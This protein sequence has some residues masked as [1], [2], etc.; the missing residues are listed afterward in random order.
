[1]KTAKRV[2]AVFIALVMAFGVFSVAVTAADLKVGDASLGTT[3][4]GLKFY[5]YVDGVPSTTPLEDGATL[6]QGDIVDVAVL[7]STDFYTH[8]VSVQVVFDKRV[9][10][11]YDGGAA[12]TAKNTKIWDSYVQKANPDN[13]KTNQDIDGVY[14]NFYDTLSSNDSAAYTGSSNNNTAGM[15]PAVWKN[16]SS[17]KADYANMTNV[18]LAFQSAAETANSGNKL[19]NVP[20]DEYARFPIIVVADEVPDGANATISVPLDCCKTASSQSTS[21]VYAKKTANNDGNSASQQNTQDWGSCKDVTNAIATFNIGASAP[22]EPTVTFKN[23]D[24]TDLAFENVTTAGG[25]TVAVSSLKAGDVIVL[26][27]PAASAIPANL[28]FK[29][30]SDGTNTYAA[31][32]QYTV[33][34]TDAT[35]TAVYAAQVTFLDKDG[36]TISNDTVDIGSKITLPAGPVVSDYNFIGWNDGTSTIS[37]DT[38]YTV[39]Q[40]TTFSATYEEVEK[41]TVRFFDKDGNELENLKMENVAAGN[42]TLPDAPAVAHHSFDG[43]AYGE[44][45]YAAGTPFAITGDTQFVAAYTEDTKYTVTFIGDDGSAIASLTDSVYAGSYTL[46]AGPQVSGKNFDGWKCV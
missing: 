44:N 22:A 26:P 35:L 11:T 10:N 36:E 14:H 31:G 32:A 13:L 40:N 34:A 17:L 37:A 15:Y 6:S 28:V 2:L 41:Y 39:N 8:N 45:T 1:M 38:E 19:I 23:S 9:Y 33:P 18:Y 12:T 7:F 5:K 46:P 21:K 27:T 20:Y 43:W 3:T 30:W 4:Y 29:H 16:G 24:G 42:I 25:D